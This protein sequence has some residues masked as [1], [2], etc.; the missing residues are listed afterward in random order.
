M[1]T[2]IN[3]TS[4]KTYGGMGARSRTY[5]N[6]E[7]EID[8]VAYSVL[9]APSRKAA[10]VQALAAVA[11]KRAH[12][13]V[14]ACG[15]R[16]EPQDPEAFVFAFPHGGSYIFGAADRGA[17]LDRLAAEYSDRDD[18]LAFVAEARAQIEAEQ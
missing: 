15:F 1:A 8:G 14:A 11:W 9:G 3:V 2:K 13:T 7:G 16:L 4:H 5:Y 18:I 10:R 17:A 6:A 12:P